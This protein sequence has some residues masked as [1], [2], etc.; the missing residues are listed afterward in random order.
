MLEA[1]YIDGFVLS[2]IKTNDTSL[3]KPFKNTFWDIV[4]FLPVKEHGKMVRYS[5]MF[6]STSVNINWSKAPKNAK[7]IRIKQ[8]QMTINGQE[9]KQQMVSI[10]FGLEYEK[11]GKVIRDTRRF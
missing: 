8:M 3:F 5:L 7:P 10:E 2:E 4:N 1:E 11:D 6:P 9:A